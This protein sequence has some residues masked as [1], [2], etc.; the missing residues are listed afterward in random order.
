MMMASNVFFSMDQVSLNK[1]NRVIATR[2]ERIAFQYAKTGFQETSYQPVGI[3]CLDCIVGAG[4]PESARSREK[5]RYGFLI[6]MYESKNELF[7]HVR[8]PKA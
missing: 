1:L 2:V 7:Y 4:R 5:R 8:D 3:D 6:E